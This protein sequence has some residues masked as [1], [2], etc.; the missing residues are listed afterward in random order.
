MPLK[1]NQYYSSTSAVACLGCSM[2]VFVAQRFSSFFFFF[3]EGHSFWPPRREFH[4]LIRYSK[5][6]LLAGHAF[7]EQTQLFVGVLLG[8]LSLWLR[9]AFSLS[10]KR[11]NH[12][13][14]LASW[15]KT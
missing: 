4:S 1:T 5:G 8:P 6:P 11:L 12:V 13:K 3:F 7:E 9:R 2:F 10:H 15:K 14:P